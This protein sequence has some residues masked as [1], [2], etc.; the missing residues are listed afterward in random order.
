MSD[1]GT[2]RVGIVTR[3]SGSGAAVSQVDA[4]LQR[5]RASAQAA[6]GGVSGLAADTRG[7]DNTFKSAAGSAAVFKSAF[8]ALGADST[9]AARSLRTAHAAAADMAPAFQ[10]AGA[11]ALNYGQTA[12][13]A[14]ALVDES[15][16]HARGAMAS[17]F[18]A[19]MRD[20]GLAGAAIGALG[21]TGI[22]AGI[23]AAVGLGAIAVALYEIISDAHQAQ[24]ALADVHAAAIVMGRAP[25][26]AEAGYAKLRDTIY[27]SGWAGRTEARGLAVALENIPHLS[28]SARQSLASVAEAW[29]KL[30][31]G[32]DEGK[33]A[34]G[35][36]RIFS[37][38]SALQSVVEKGHLLA[39]EA[40]T[41]FETAIATHDWGKASDLA[42]QGI[43]QRYGAA[44]Q[45]IAADQKKFIEEL[46]RGD[47]PLGALASIPTGAALTRSLPAPLNLP[48]QEEADTSK[49]IADTT[50]LRGIDA[51]RA[52]TAAEI[53]RLQKAIS[54]N[55][56]GD[57]A[58]A[59]KALD[60]LK[61][62]LALE[63][64]Q[65]A[66]RGARAADPAAMQGIRE[67]VEQAGYQAA[68]KGAADI[69]TLRKNE[70]S[71]EIGVLQKEV[72]AA[73]RAGDQRVGIE[74]LTVQQITQLRAEL[75]G[76]QLELKNMEASASQR[77]ATQQARADY[78]T[79]IRNEE[80]KLRAK[81]AMG[82]LTKGDIET[83]FQ[84]RSAE[85]GKLPTVQQAPARAGLQLQEIEQ[86]KQLQTAI[87]SAQ[88]EQ[89]RSAE[90]NLTAQNR[91]AN[92]GLAMKR[93][94]LQTGVAAN[95][96]AKD[97]ELA[98]EATL[99]SQVMAQEE[100]RT[101]AAL[102]AD[103]LTLG[104]RQKLNEQLAELYAKDAETQAQYQEKIT[105]K[106]DA[107]NKARAQ[108]FTSFFDTT[109]DALEKFITE[110]MT[111]TTTFRAAE[112]Q[113]V[114]GLIG[115]AVKGV[116]GEGSKFLG[117]KL[118]DMAGVKLPEG[119]GLG[120]A[121]GLSLE[122]A[123]GMYKEP[124]KTA[125]ER[126]VSALG[127][128]KKAL[129]VQTGILKEI[130]ANT[131]KGQREAR[132]TG[133]GAGTGAPGTMVPG[134]A[135]TQP[136]AVGIGDTDQTAALVRKYESHG[137]YNVGYGQTDLSNAPLSATGF[138]QWGGNMGPA[139]RSHAAGAYQFEPKTWDQYAKPLGVTDFSKSS[140]DRVFQADYQQHGLRDWS[141]DKPLMAA[142][143]SQGA[144]TGAATQDPQLV[145]GLR[146]LTQQAQ[147]SATVA[148]QGIGVTQAGTT[149]AQQL[150]GSVGQDKTATD[151]LKTSVDK[152]TQA[153]TTAAQK[154]TGGSSGSGSGGSGNA[155][156][157][158]QLFTQGLGI[159]SSAAALFGSRLS[160]A[161]REILGAVGVIS[162][163][164]SFGKNLSS[165]F[166]L[167]ETTTKTVTSATQLA[168]TATT[169]MQLANV[170]N[171]V[172]TT[173]NTVAT[174]ANSSAQA[175][176]GGA[177]LLSKIPLIGAL[178][179]A[180]G[181]IIPSAAGGMISGGGQM[182]ILHPNEMVLPAHISAAV[183]G[184][185]HAGLSP[186]SMRPSNDN[187][188]G[189]GNTTNN[190]GGNHTFNYSP[191]M[192]G[193]FGGM[194]RGEVEGTLRSHGSAFEGYARNAMRNG[195]RG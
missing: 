22:A 30:Q 28:D 60:I 137:N 19:M 182:A 160:P 56:T 157:G 118:A 135:L 169:T 53:A 193:R 40:Y 138:P 162:Q 6:Q 58:G 146:N 35:F 153:T 17:S 132:G 39:G 10:K 82:T 184:A 112:K 176:A 1:D 94:Q 134:G 62:H 55:Q 166:G 71:A 106:I 144:G 8:A 142:A 36:A 75:V 101:I 136:G 15:F 108:T 177:S 127:D 173:A 152:S 163:L 185:A 133:T 11:A 27:E 145:T 115:D 143:G 69:A 91:I 80:A 188:A 120:S 194:S 61:E 90:E 154:G 38:P 78:E 190:S 41:A 98:A 140:Q 117:G 103:D 77:S 99:T 12:R 87:K 155:S 21:P 97:Q 93:A 44:Q 59:Q 165:A 46:K 81:Q 57:A 123:L 149:Q 89:F 121:L 195:F 24:Q 86:Q 70:L 34:K 5:I 139:G 141:S 111:R 4:S 16:R 128:E 18:I 7:L 63:D 23:A 105:S 172:A 104:Q 33:A 179:G 52:K 130:A 175:T 95:S 83:S 31:F 47:D 125:Q 124:P 3:E 45:K 168:G 164:S 79:F 66:K 171:T 181:G 9:E 189:T 54:D 100:Q 20:S 158:L 150:N 51:E 26:E 13:H 178:F 32:G 129:D 113:L 151:A 72:D 148:Q 131:K 29:A 88:A 122:K 107:E 85:A 50:A 180:Q 74:K 14:V 76:K 84:A 65:I 116:M 186:G 68:A 2:V 37:S 174:T 167:A 109:G 192:S 159:A 161:T 96:A 92:M 156:S 67:R 170:G 183:Q 48:T 102:Q 110:S 64:Q 147:A 73:Q 119:G 114:T 187:L 126:V 42:A 43:S 25:A 49:L 191:Q